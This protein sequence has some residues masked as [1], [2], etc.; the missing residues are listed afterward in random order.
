MIK[1]VITK[2]EHEI[3]DHRFRLRECLAILDGLDDEAIEKKE[4]RQ[5]E[6]DL[7]KNILRIL[8][9]YIGV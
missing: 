1:G 5:S 2:D 4:V 9:T 6:T 8:E 3:A 7:I